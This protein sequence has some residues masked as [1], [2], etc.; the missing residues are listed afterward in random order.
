MIW[1]QDGG[2]KK[3]V[4]YGLTVHRIRENSNFLLALDEAELI[5]LTPYGLTYYYSLQD[6]VRDQRGKDSHFLL[7]TGMP[8]PLPVVTFWPGLYTQGGESPV[9]APTARQVQ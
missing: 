5:N 2:T 6:R 9:A 3:V 4:P 7:H 8:L 1:K